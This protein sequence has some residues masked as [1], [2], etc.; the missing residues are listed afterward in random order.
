MRRAWLLAPLALVACSPGVG[1]DPVYPDA[2]VRAEAG[3]P[4]V[5]PPDA[6]SADAGPRD[7]PVFLPDSGPR[8]RFPFTGVFSILDDPAS[9]FA[10]EVQG[11]LHIVVGDFPYT[12][13]GTI[14]EDGAV[15]LGSTELTASGCPEPRITGTYS[16]EDTL[17]MLLHETCNGRGE[18]VSANLRG[19]FVADFDPAVSGEYEVRMQVVTDPMG[20]FGLGPVP[21]AGRWGLDVLSDRTLAVFVAYDPVGP[22]AVYF[23]RAQ[24]NLSS[25]TAVHHLDA[26]VNGPQV[27]MSAQLVQPTANDPVQMIGTRDVYL[28]DTGCT[29]SVSFEATRVAAP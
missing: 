16:R 10:R 4:D 3:V 24:A 11:R 9:L 6:G 21:Q 23:G 14:D 28:P 13:V 25:F 17:H 1:R 8:P 2:A 5:G 22:P 18:P 12:Y 27:A 15:D 19:G 20:C 26:Q 7:V 29:F